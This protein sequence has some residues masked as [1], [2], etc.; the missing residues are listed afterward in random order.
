MKSPADVSDLDFSTA[1][2]LLDIGKL[3]G[4]YYLAYFANRFE[5]PVNEHFYADK[6]VQKKLKDRHFDLVFADY[7]YTFGR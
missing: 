5:F 3:S 6:V 1:E 2:K 4:Q 7:L